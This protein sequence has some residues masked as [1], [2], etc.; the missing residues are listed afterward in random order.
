MAGPGLA[1]QGKARQG[2]ETADSALETVRYLMQQHHMA[3]RG[4]AW[5][6]AAGRGEVWRSRARQGLVFSWLPIRKSGL[7]GEKS[8]QSQAWRGVAGQGKARQGVLAGLRPQPF[9]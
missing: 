2:L 8:P 4:P 1:R 7:P 9:T 3:W 6:G 5:L